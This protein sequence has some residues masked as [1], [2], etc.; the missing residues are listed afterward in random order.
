MASNQFPHLPR[1]LVYLITDRR[2]LRPSPGKDPIAVLADFIAA[3]FAA[4]VDLVQ[5]RERDLSAQTLYTLVSDS[6]RIAREYS[7]HVLVNDRADV[8]VAAGAGVHLTTRSISVEVI[9][10]RFGES[11][12]IGASTHSLA[13]AQAAER[14]GSDFIVFGP[15]FETPSKSGYGPPVG[16]E[17]LRDVAGQVAIPLL[18]LG[19]I[20]VSNFTAALDAGSTGIAGISI[21]AGAS[22]LAGAVNVLKR[23]K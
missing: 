18:A 17:T 2:Q 13:E 11:L 5:I 20:T 1:P 16:P 22:D 4:G 10:R 14:G 23:R 3:A 19:G 9:R 6:V 15:A 7:R 12:L 21:F 8:A